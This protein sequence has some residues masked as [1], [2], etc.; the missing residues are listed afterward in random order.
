M[1]KE[2]LVWLFETARKMESIVE[3]GSW[4]GRSTHALLSGCRGTVYA[5]DH[6]KGSMAEIG[7]DQSHFEATIRDI[8]VDFLK[9]VGMFTNLVV[10]K[11]NSVD[12]A[13]KFKPGSID[14]V[15]IDGGH[16]YDDIYLDLEAWAPIARRLVC[17]HDYGSEV[18]DAVDK[19]FGEKRVE[20]MGSGIWM[21]WL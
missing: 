6:F 3:V 14:M 16:T 19:K 15:F 8:S 17:G 7:R 18:K 4:K 21:V 11:A 9:N 1:P 10:L 20:T 5:V 2:N 13:K 12:A